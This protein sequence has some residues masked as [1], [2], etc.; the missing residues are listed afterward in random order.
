M[1]HRL[2]NTFSEFDKINQ[3]NQINAKHVSQSVEAFTGAKDYDITI[4]GTLEIRGEGNQ[5]KFKIDGGAF[6]EISSPNSYIVSDAAGNIG[7]NPTLSTSG[8]SGR[9][10]TNG[11]SGTSG[12]AGTS[13]TSGTA[14]SSGTS[15]TS[16]T[17]GPI[18]AGQMSYIRPSIS[19]SGYQSLTL[20]GSGYSA[21]L[22]KGYNRL[23]VTNTAGNGADLILQINP[24]DLPTVGDEV[25]VE[26]QTPS[27]SFM[28]LKYRYQTGTGTGSLDTH[29]I[30]GMVNSEGIQGLQV[31]NFSRTSSPVF[32]VFRYVSI[33]NDVATGGAGTESSPVNYG[34]ILQAA[35]SM[36]NTIV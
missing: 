28:N 26:L 29:I 25:F 21:N 4:S 6:N 2:T 22:S 3:G 33:I 32:C 30:S 10:G 18:G 13:G 27:T 24:N 36:K 14:G 11:A 34:L 7:F 5:T 1:G 35:R 15:G 17:S 31:I 20:S 19:G 23:E 12:T 9:A 16:G 8:T